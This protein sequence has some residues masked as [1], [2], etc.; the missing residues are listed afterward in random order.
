MKTVSLGQEKLIKKHC[1][2]KCRHLKRK[3]ECVLK[4]GVENPFQLEDVKDKIKNTCIERYGEEHHLRSKEILEKRNITCLEKYG[5][6]NVAQSIQVKNKIKNTIEQNPEITKKAQRKRERTN[7]VRYGNKHYFLSNDCKEKL[8]NKIGV[9]NAFKSPDILSKIR[10]SHLK[11][12]GVNHHFKIRDEAIKNAAKG[13][14]TKIK[15][16]QIATHENKTKTEW[17]NHLG[18]SK[19]HFTSLVNNYGWDEAVTYLP[20]ISTLESIVKKLLDSI[21]VTYL[22]NAKL[23]N[24]KPDFI[25]D[26]HK[27]IIEC[28]GL[29]YHSEAIQSD[30]SYH[31]KKKRYYDDMGYR[32]L[33]FRENEILNMTEIVN[34]VI[35]NKIGKTSRIFA[36]KLNTY[37]ASKSEAKQFFNENHLM[38]NGRGS[39]VF[40]TDGSSIYAGMQFRRTKNDEW[41][42]SRFCC[43]KGWSVTGGFSK[44]I[45]SFYLNNSMSSLTTFVDRRYGDGEY[46]SLL[47]FNFVSCYKSFQWTD[48]KNTFHRMRFKSNSGYDFGLHKIWDCGQAKYVKLFD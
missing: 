3:E 37:Q 18:I 26:D 13:L 19:S 5:V 35:L 38:G 46:L 32:S 36:R 43:A 42:I 30:N 29:Y 24:Y 31:I 41:E 48:T 21:G 39:T 2:I 17:A 22:H 9:D 6:K 1:C 16:G 4:Y 12:R 15:T 20:K 33:F 11:R 10:Q 27:L 47:G 40:L 34:S 45:S 28:D 7:L 44:L 14:A 8:K 23:G 25:L